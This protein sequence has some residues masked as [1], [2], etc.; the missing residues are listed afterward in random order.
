MS[1]QLSPRTIVRCLAAAAAL[2]A[3]ASLSLGAHAMS[4][5]AISQTKVSGSYRLKLVIGPAETMSMTT[6]GNAAER[7]LGGKNATCQMGMLMEAV[8]AGVNASMMK[9]CN[10]HVEVHVYNKTSGKVVTNATVSIVMVEP[11][12]HGMMITVPIM[13]MEGM[14]AGPSDYHYG[15]NIYAAAGKYTVKV[16]ANKVKANFAVTLSRGM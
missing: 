6:K 7:M 4:P 3:A 9:T 11:G 2:T 14:H 15:N 10:Y 13:S 8:P 1:M 16:T 5:S 12:M